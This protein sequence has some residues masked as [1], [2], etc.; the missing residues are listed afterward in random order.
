MSAEKR[1]SRPKMNRSKS[2][3]LTVSMIPIM[4]YFLLFSVYPVVSAF[5]ISFFDWGL[6]DRNHTFI[7]LENYITTFTDPDFWV[8]VK[9]TLYFAVLNVLGQTI[10]GLLLAVF[11]NSLTKG[12]MT[13]MRTV[14]FIPV[15]TSMVAVA[16]MFDWLYQPAFGIINY[17][18]SFLGLGPYDFLT[19]AT[20]VIPSIVIMTV[21]KN[22]G[23]TMVIFIAGLTTIPHDLYEAAEIDGANKAKQFFTITLPLL[24]PTTMFVTITSVISSLQVF[25][26]IYSTTNGG[27]GIASRTIVIEI[28]ESAFKFFEM[29]KATSMAFVLFLLIMV[30]T[31]IQMRLM[32]SNLEY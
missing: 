1:A 25:T 14:L 12:L 32:R 9:N 23:Y 15:V 17:M 31:L 29:G 28:Y 26:Q 20:Q 3:F 24:K 21:W 16:L 8:V 13:V 19:S 11:V 30:F 2:I 27:P 4:L 7:G 18:L 5:V 6:M 10:L 22:V